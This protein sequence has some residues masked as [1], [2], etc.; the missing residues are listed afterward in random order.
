MCYFWLPEM[1]VPF[2]SIILP[3]YNR[4]SLLPGSIGSVIKQSYQGW[5]LVVVDDGSTDNTQDVV[6]SFNDPRIKYVYQNNSERSAARNKGID[7]A[8]G[9]WICFLDSDD[10]YLPEHLEVLNIF[11]MN[12]SAPRFIVTGSIIDYKHSQKKHPLMDKNANQLIELATKFVLMN[13]ICVHK[14]LL[15]KE[16][17]NTSYSLWE[18][19]HLW[20][21]I[22]AQ[23]PVYQIA[24][25]TVV[26]HVHEQ[27]TVVQ[28]M[29]KIRKE[30]AYQY[31]N[32]IQDLRDKHAAL[33]EG[34]LP[35]NFFN[36]YIDSKYRMY[37]Y[38][39]RQNRQF[40]VASQL[41]MK[42]WKHRP[43]WYL[44]TE[45]PKIALNFINI[46]LHAR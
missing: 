1:S 23:Y 24:Q 11:L 46:G 27:G 38:Q 6:K 37:V 35:P 15:E 40:R 14:Q 34:K 9:T 39:A 16:R 29:K 36:Q 8:S 33:F 19:T 22:A 18:D 26:Q 10:E 3:T 41:W 21:R 44:V 32:A 4:A 12:N 20:L 17:F 2:F 7:Y 43:S 45:F 30:E 25:Y 5:E 28:G 42:A 31:V 13:S